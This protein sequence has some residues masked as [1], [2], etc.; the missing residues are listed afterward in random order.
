MWC[1]SVQTRNFTFPLHTEEL[2]NPLSTIHNEAVPFFDTIVAPITGPGPAAVAIVRLSGPRAWLIASKTFEPWPQN[3]EPRRAIYGRYA[4]GDDGLALPFE[5]G[6]SY[7]GEQT[8]EMSLHGSPP[9][10][11]AL[12]AACIQADARMARPGEFTERAFLSGR[13]DLT[14]AEAVRDTV[15][16]QTDA[17]LRLANLHREGALNREVAALAEETLSLLA[18]I[19]ASVDFSEEIGELD[20]SAATR[21]IGALLENVGKLLATA[22]SGRI[23]RE[24]LRI[25]IVGP[26]NAGKSSL[27]NRLLG[28][29][30]SIVADTPGTTRDYVEE[31]ADLGGVPC[32][33]ID[34]AGLRET[35]DEVESIGVNRSRLIAANADLVWYV[36]DATSCVSRQHGEGAG[37]FVRADL[38]TNDS[39]RFWLMANKCDLLRAPQP[40]N[41][42]RPTP[43]HQDPKPQTPNPEPHPISALTGQGIPALIGRLRAYADLDR[44][45]G[46]RIAPRHAPLLERTRTALQ[47]VQ[48][49]LQSPVP[50]DLAAVGLRDAAQALGEITG[51]TTTP[52]IIERIFH[53]FCIGK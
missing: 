3:P 36:F 16:A 23:L 30:R 15:E 19:E 32:V 24:G 1:G 10:V 45:P 17:Q 21:R 34:T 51:E 29:D 26:P 50:D 12:V 44:D 25:A 43:Q 9:S 20:R 37:W 33:L 31:R 48:T 22:E 6:H 2:H 14:Q 28:H 52:D 46:P 8:V 35:D 40:A 13:I 11:R 47:Q 41:T 7:T 5:E 38:P 39:E 53:D 18:A 42:Q 27:L 4:T 49:V